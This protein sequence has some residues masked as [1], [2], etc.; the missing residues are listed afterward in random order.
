M[1][2]LYMVK[3][4]IKIHGWPTD[5]LRLGPATCGQAR[6][7]RKAD[8]RTTHA[9]AEAVGRPSM[10]DAEVVYAFVYDRPCNAHESV[11]DPEHRKKVGLRANL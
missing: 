5:T 11:R 7:N 10:F 4:H 1:N 2:I 3:E 6:P 8:C 9:Y